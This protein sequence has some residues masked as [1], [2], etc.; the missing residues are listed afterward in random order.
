[1]EKIIVFDNIVQPHSNGIAGDTQKV[2]VRCSEEEMSRLKDISLRAKQ[3]GD[4]FRKRLR[5]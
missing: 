4:V 2:K 1:M 3:A 5:V